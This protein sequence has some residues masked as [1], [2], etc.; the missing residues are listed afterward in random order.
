VKKKKDINDYGRNYKQHMIQLHKHFIDN[1]RPIKQ[2]INITEVIKYV[3]D[4]HPSVFMYC[5]NHN[6]RKKKIDDTKADTQL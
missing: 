4:L 3:N 6:I 5:L 1:L 2:F